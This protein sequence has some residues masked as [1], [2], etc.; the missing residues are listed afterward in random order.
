M[1]SNRRSVIAQ[2][3]RAP[4]VF[5]LH[6]P[7]TAG[8]TIR[9]LLERNALKTGQRV[10]AIY[11]QFTFPY[12]TEH[13]I[14]IDNLIDAINQGNATKKQILSKFASGL[15]R[16][17]YNAE[18]IE[19]N[20]CDL[21]STHTVYSADMVRSL[22]GDDV[23]HLVTMRHP[24]TMLASWMNHGNWYKHWKLDQYPD[25]VKTFLTN[26]LKFDKA[27]QTVNHMIGLFG[28]R[29]EQEKKKTK[30]EI[31]ETIN[32]TFD[33]I[34][35]E[36]IDES[37]LLLR[38]KYGWS[39]RDILTVELN[40]RNYTEK[41][42]VYSDDL[43]ELHRKWS[44]L[45]FQLYEMFLTRHENLVAEGGQEFQREL[46]E[47]H[48]WRKPHDV[49]CRDIC[50]L[51]Q[52]ATLKLRSQTNFEGLLRNIS[53]FFTNLP[54]NKYTE[55]VEISG[56]DCLLEATNVKVLHFMLQFLQSPELCEPKALDI[57]PSVVN[58][59]L[60]RKHIN[61]LCSNNET[62]K[63]FYNLPF[64]SLSVTDLDACMI[65]KRP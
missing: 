16:R 63:L 1:I 64:K 11:T 34:I 65:Q 35:Y 19:Q 24:T 57:F 26:P 20:Q 32:S 33:A 8:S 15:A 51:I 37:L 41:T 53:K 45:D 9:S 55:K 61:G 58:E 50:Q 22:M 25:R 48:K 12:V 28:Y 42:R 52:M 6:I 60:D 18:A 10:P 56:T 4:K 30:E 49:L 39:W 27:N 40:I 54:L 13:L 5:Y 7:K 14:P 43:F 36:R 29:K 17:N 46:N 59:I 31:F 62:D 47:F 2:K 44:P 23:L 38:R 21:I 3:S